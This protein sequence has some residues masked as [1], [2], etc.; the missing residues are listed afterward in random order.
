MD[1]LRF[2]ETVDGFG[3]RVVVAIADAADRGFDAGFSSIA[4]CI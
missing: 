3:E 2:V 1:D 4:R